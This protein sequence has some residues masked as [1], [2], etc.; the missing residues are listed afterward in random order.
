MGRASRSGRRAS[1]RRASARKGRPT[2]SRARARAGGARGNAG[3]V[4]CFEMTGA[5][6]AATIAALELEIRRVARRYDAEIEDFQ[7]KVRLRSG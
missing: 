6:D 2:G 3:T 5:M 1:G 7:V 4:H